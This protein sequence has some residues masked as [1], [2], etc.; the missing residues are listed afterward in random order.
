[1][2]W[3]TETGTGTYVGGWNVSGDVIA[4]DVANISTGERITREIRLRQTID[5]PIIVFFM[6]RS[7]YFDGIY[8]K[9]P[10]KGNGM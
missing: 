7:D 2:V 10:G 9:P 1:M 6:D 4:L 3:P 5:G 8:R